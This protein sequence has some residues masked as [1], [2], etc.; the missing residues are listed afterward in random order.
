MESKSMT[1]KLLTETLDNLDIG[2]HF[3]IN[4]CVVQTLLPCF[5]S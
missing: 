4:K 1:P 5:T 2:K 3:H